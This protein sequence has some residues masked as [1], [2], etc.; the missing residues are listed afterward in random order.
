M[1]TRSVGM[2]FHVTPSARELYKALPSLIHV[3]TG[4][5]G[6]V[7]VVVIA[8]R[9]VVMVVDVVVVV[10]VVVVVVSDVVVVVVLQ[11]KRHAE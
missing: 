1:D 9:T 11:N 2:L 10:E 5:C 8:V 7:V 4:H 6:S 3:G